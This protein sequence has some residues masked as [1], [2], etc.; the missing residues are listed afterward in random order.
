MAVVLGAVGLNVGISVVGLNVGLSV[1]LSVAVGDGGA[2]E[3][4]DVGFDVTGCKVDG[5]ELTGCVVEHLS[6]SHSGP[7]TLGN[8]VPATRLHASISEKDPP[9]GL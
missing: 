2:D 8:S 6:G 9:L 7:H 1:G 4:Q 3:G 5:R